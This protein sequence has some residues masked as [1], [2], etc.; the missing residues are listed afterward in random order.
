M[1]DPK[2]RLLSIDLLDGGELA[3]LDEWGNRAVLTRPVVGVTIPELF[4]AQVAHAPEAVALVCG[5]RS[6]TYR[7]VDET[8]ERLARVLTGHGAGPG[9]TVA[10]LFS[11]SA[12]AIVTMMAVL[13]AGAAYLP[14]DPALPD[15]RVEFM[16][17]DATPVAAVTT[18]ALR[19]RLDGTDLVVVDFDD[20]GADPGTE[21]SAPAAGDLA[22]MIYTSGTTGVPKGVAITHQNATSLLEKLHSGVPSGPGQVWSQWHSYSFDVS[23]WEIFGALLHGGRLVIVP[24]TVASSPED[25]HSL[26]VAEKVSVLCQTPSAAA[27][28]SSEGLESTAVFV[29][30]E[31]LPSE[32]VDRW[33][34]GRVLI[35]AYGP[36]EGTIYAAMSAPLTPGAPA[37]IGVPVPGAALFVLD[38]WLRPALEG[39]TGELYIA[40]R[41]VA[42]GYVRRAP[43]DRVAVRGMSVR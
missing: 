4:A 7:E 25:L 19:S 3:R 29:A 35:D 20:P 39:V 23:V 18:A 42:A 32:V 40:G 36:T 11:R 22:Y 14:I 27:M 16:L 28:L 9:E 13:K 26:L 15:A 33:A 1:A 37:P 2:R 34:P 43:S 24:E 17:G 41:G 8:A 10:L 6:W 5:E 21:L 31:A 30:G 12:E 38:K